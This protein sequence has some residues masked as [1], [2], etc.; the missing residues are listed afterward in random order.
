MKILYLKYFISTLTTPI[1]LYNSEYIQSP[2]LRS[3]PSIQ[4]G[5]TDSLGMTRIYRAGSTI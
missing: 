3:V 2:T 4:T 5:V 1:A